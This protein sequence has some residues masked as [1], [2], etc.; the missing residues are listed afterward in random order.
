MG[1][2]KPSPFRLSRRGWVTLAVVALVLSSYMADSVASVGRIRSGVKAGSLELGGHADEEARTLLTERA[3]LLLSQPVEAFADTRRVSAAPSEIDFEPNV[4]ATLRTAMD[5]GRRGN[6][7]VRV[8]HRVRALFASTD[9]GWQSDFDGDTLERIVRTWAEAIDT[10]GHE[11]G[12]EARGDTIVALGAVPARKLDRKAAMDVV[13]EGLETWPRRSMELPLAV[14]QRRTDIEDARKAAE[15]ANEWIRAPIRLAAPD[16]S[17]TT[18]SRVA[19]AG[20]LE[21]VPRRN[22]GQWELEVRFSPKRVADELGD[23]MKAYEQDA[24]SASFVVQGSRVSVAAAEEGRTFDAK[25]TAIEL[26]KAARRDEPRTA[27]AVFDD[28]EPELSTEQARA[29]K[30]TELVST[31]TTN[32]P[33][34]QTRVKNIHRIA[35]TVDDAIVRPGESFS[36]NDYVGERTVEK[37][38]LL[39]PM[40]YDGEF[41]D[42]VGGGVS[43]F[44][45]TMYNAIFFGGY[46]IDSHKAHTY[47]I[48]RYPPGREAT[49]SY[50]SPDLKFTNTSGAGILIKT[51]YSETSITVSFYG[52]KEGKLVTAEA[53]PRTN[54]TNYETRYVENPALPRGSQKVVQKGGQGFDIVVWRIITQN[55]QERREKFFTRYRAQP[56]IIEVSSE[57]SPCPTPATGEFPFEATPCPTAPSAPASPAP[58]PSPEPSP[59]PS[60]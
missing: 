7:I 16:G 9:V 50:P 34:C 57:G 52:D 11:A 2:R 36:L 60:P 28:V 13:V 47:Y 12:I 8:W 39:A 5:V 37:G 59:S 23:V 17:R 3:E 4:E 40:I 10:P 15:T 22:V 54:P 33:C 42:A 1:V 30:I 53:G 19:L 41:R 14:E 18:L 38:Y 29:L 43:Q 46:K 45:T 24:K 26:A 20:M 44:A 51:S 48:S 55:G 32:H 35:D 21:A 25:A 27:Q 58:S 6:V 56:E 49:V 31:F